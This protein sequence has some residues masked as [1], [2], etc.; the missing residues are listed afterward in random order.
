MSKKRKDIKG[1][2]RA[3]NKKNAEVRQSQHAVKT[4]KKQIKLP[5]IP[6]FPL[7]FVLAWF[8]CSLIY[9]NVFYIAEQYSYLAFDKTIMQNV[10]DMNTGILILIGR[11]LLLSFHY[12]LFGGLLMAVMLTTCSWLIDY[13]F[14]LKGFKRLIAYVLPF[15]YLAWD[16]FQGFNLYYQ[17]EPAYIFIYPFVAL[18]VLV[19]VGVAVRLKTKRRITAFWKAGREEQ[20]KVRSFSFLTIVI[21]FAG[22]IVFA[23]PFR[24]NTQTTVKMQRMME[25]NDW[26][27]MIEAALKVKR[28]SRSVCCYYAIALTQSGQIGTR[29]FDI[30][31][32]YPNMH[33]HTRTG[34]PDATTE[35]Y[36]CDGDFYAGLINTSY[37]ECMEHSVIDGPSILR[38]K[39]MY[40]C[41]LLNGELELGYKYLNLISKMPFESA[42]VQKYGPLLYS[43]SMVKKDPDLAKVAEVIPLEDSFEQWYR[44]PLFI[45]YNVMLSS[46]RSMRALYNSLAACLYNKDL[47]A[48]YIRTL[49][50]RGGTLPKNFEEAVVLYGLKDADRIKAFQVSPVTLETTKSFLSDALNYKG[51]NRKEVYYKLCSQYLGYYPFYYYF[52]NI[53]DENYFLTN[54]EKGRVN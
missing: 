25:D 39:R 9:N 12:P 43:P 11:F 13:D 10:L 18:V 20:N 24:V 22:L 34:E 31:Y 32:Q 17:N 47:E 35:Y 27:D 14:N 29:L 53:P 41:T 1:T 2:Y 4:K 51:Q 37:H 33:I 26:D 21:V 40:L 38:L 7:I 45:G 23:V 16:V 52:E 8:F 50:L 28:P 49:P 54:R 15:L 48:F 6:P 30:H 46:G 5:F 3:P 36:A 42:F 44:T 19:L